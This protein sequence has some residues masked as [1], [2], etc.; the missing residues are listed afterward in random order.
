MM[1][2][3]QSDIIVIGGGMAG[4]AVA[5]HLSENAT[6]RLLE[7]ENHPGYHST[8]RSAA[9]FS[10]NYGNS[11]IRALSRAS[12]EFFFSPPAGFCETALVRPR[13]VLI[14]AQEHQRD[15]LAHY[16]IDLEADGTTEEIS[17]DEAVLHCPILRRER[18]ASALINRESADIEVHELQQGYLRL[19]KARGGTIVTNAEVVGLS[20][21]SQDWQV[22]TRGAVYRAARVV[23]AAG[24]W[25]A[26]VGALAGAQE[27]DMTPCKRTA[28]LVDPPAG[29]ETRHWPMVLD[30]AEQF[31]LKPDAG[32]LLL[33]PA[34]ETAVE[35]G[36]VQP[37]EMDI[38]IA[39]DR[40][41]TA[42][43]LQIRRFRRKWAGLRSFVPDRS[44]IVG[45]DHQQP[46]FFWLAALGGYGIQTAPALSAL[47]A[48]LVRGLTPGDDAARFGV[49]VSAIDPAR[50]AEPTRVAGHSG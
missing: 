1:S 14:V 13:P 10:E 33:S 43:T 41:E 39:V 17:A 32:L 46:G 30:V 40:I 37:D 28:A 19:L 2:D 18:L 34:D 21:V 36:D 35:P 3:L 31:Y 6:V 38:A 5:A 9:L 25:A 45:Y 49:H 50:L 24:A 42:T 48:R 16:K 15:L 22:E 11:V 26:Q 8:G 4:A 44:P 12:R 23:N 20:R 47:A 29:Q 27:V 7:M